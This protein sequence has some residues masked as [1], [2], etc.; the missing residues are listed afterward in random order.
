MTDIAMTATTRKRSKRMSGKAIAQ[1]RS[2]MDLHVNDFAACLG[3]SPASVYRWETTP[4]PRPRP[5]V[6][7]VL[8]ALATLS[9]GDLAT[10]GV[11]IKSVFTANSPTAA[12]TASQLVLAAITRPIE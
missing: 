6:A 11:A 3:V 10:L 8:A 12:I 9:S 5:S 4:K 7:K 1:V 2:Q